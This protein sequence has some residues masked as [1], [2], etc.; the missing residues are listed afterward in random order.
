MDNN[1]SEITAKECIE[2]CIIRHNF[3]I[4]SLKPGYSFDF[5]TDIEYTRNV[6][7]LQVYLS[8]TKYEL[9][10]N[11]T[12]LK[13]RYQKFITLASID[14]K[15]Y[16]R[17]LMPQNQIDKISY[18]E[19]CLYYR[20]CLGGMSHYRFVQNDSFNFYIMIF[21]CLFDVFGPFRKIQILNILYI[22]Q[23]DTLVEK[24]R[25]NI[26]IMFPGW[27]LGNKTETMGEIE[28]QLSIMI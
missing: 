25:D 12:E 21:W 26:L 5:Y 2:L 15:L 16:M 6:S 13:L 4:Q 10:S 3:E 9:L 27:D 22:L 1:V 11:F 19:I 14:K 20:F 18:I 7:S 28:K 23:D 24:N 17:L 8:D